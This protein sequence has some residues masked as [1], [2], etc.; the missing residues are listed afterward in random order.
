MPP[1]AVL[2]MDL[3]VDFLDTARGRMPVGD[4]G[5]ARVLTAAHAVL[6]GAVLPEAVVVAIANEFPATQVIANFFRRRAAIVGSPGAALDPR[7]D[8]D[9][10]VPRFAKSAASAFSNPAL[11]PYL[12]SKGIRRICLVGVFAEGCIRATALAG[13]ALGY[14]VLAPLDAIATN[15]RWKQW[16]A[17]RSMRRHG[18]VLPST[19]AEVAT[20]V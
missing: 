11:H 12:R 17:V 8:L 16:F 10:S 2:L 1:T 15:A 6:A 3:Q 5:T 18:V 4:E 14:S 13:A 7:L 20:A 9:S 19:L